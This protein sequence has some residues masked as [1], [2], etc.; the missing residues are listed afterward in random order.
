VTDAAQRTSDDPFGPGALVGPV[1]RAMR[2]AVIAVDPAGLVRVWDGAATALLGWREHEVLGRPLAALQAP[3]DPHPLQER[4]HAVLAGGDA[5]GEWLAC[6][7]DGAPVRLAVRASVLPGPGGAAGV[8]L[9]ARDAADAGDRGALHRRE[10][11]FRALAESLPAV[12]FTAAADGRTDYLNSRWTDVTGHLPGESLGAGWLRQ[13]HPDDQSRTWAAWQH[14]LRH[15]TPFE[16]EFRLGS[17]ARGWRWHLGRALPL[18]ALDDPPRWVG[19]CT[20][21]HDQRLL[22]EALARERAFAESVLATAPVALCVLDTEFRYLRVNEAFARINGMPV[23]EHVGRRAPEVVPELWPMLEPIFRRV[24]DTGEPLLDLEVEGASRADPGTPRAWIG[25]YF[26]VRQDGAITG[27]GIALVDITP[28]K[29]AERAL[30]EADR[31]KDEFLATLAHELRNPLSPIR[32]AVQML[33]D[34]ATGADDAAWAR[35]M[36]DRQVGHL[37]RLIDELLDVARIGRGKLVLRREPVGLADVVQAALEASRPLLEAR[38]QAL[39]VSLPDEPLALE[40]DAVRL[41]QALTNVLSNAAKFSEPGGRVALLVRREG[42]EGVVEVRDAG[43]GIAPEELPRLFDLFYQSR[44]AREHAM[45]GLGI[46]LALV[47]QIVELHGGRVAA[48]SPGRGQGSVFTLRLPLAPVPARAAA[49]RPA[50]PPPAAPARILVADD[51]ADSALGLA[52]LLRGA[53]HDVEVA[54]DGEEA[55]A[56]AE[57]HQPEVVLLDIGMPRLDGYAVCRRLRRRAGAGMLIVAQTGW[58]QAADRERA[59]EAGFDAHFVK[60]VDLAALFR[61][62]ADRGR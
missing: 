1:L 15:G 25:N 49:A 41:V 43:I 34:P 2:D 17:E 53:G 23:A 28:Q 29:R 35:G 60:P 5:A 59:R 33:Q 38:R 12:V 42:G 13:V 40:G 6:R 36:I 30:R 7:E 16:V 11:E 62:L 3:G 20:D 54:F 45:G 14:H 56:L 52:A 47:R 48:A 57:R 8:L 31:H 26:P 50:P 32:I 39:A 10:T 4:L 37:V 19:S 24:L 55:L 9:L 18:P 58:G 44:D 51:N 61:L 21:I 22:R 46:G 27:L